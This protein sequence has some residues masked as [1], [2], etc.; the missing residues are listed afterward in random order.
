MTELNC[1]SLDDTLCAANSH[2][3]PPLKRRVYVF[4][5]CFRAETT[6]Q[7]K[8]DNVFPYIDGPTCIADV[9][10]SHGS[11]TGGPGHAVTA[12]QPC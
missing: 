5:I 11:G 6:N 7:A 12:F 9:I 10:V 4:V 2:N 8:N 3:L 1:Y